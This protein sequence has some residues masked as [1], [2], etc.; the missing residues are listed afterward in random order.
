MLSIAASFAFWASVVLIMKNILGFIGVVV[1]ES[2]KFTISV[3]E[4]W[5]LISSIAWVITYITHIV[6]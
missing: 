4:K 3:A 5:L 6:F 1:R 2:G